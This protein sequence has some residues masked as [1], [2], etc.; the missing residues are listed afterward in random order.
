M[1]NFGPLEQG[2][3]F[4]SKSVSDCERVAG[5]GMVELKRNFARIPWPSTVGV[6]FWVDRLTAWDE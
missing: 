5:G 6:I 2:F 1:P 4:T 3:F